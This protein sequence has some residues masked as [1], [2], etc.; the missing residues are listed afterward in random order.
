MK[1]MVCEICGSQSI[2][3]ENGVFICQEC[4]TEYSLEE[5]KKLLKEI[6]DEA[7]NVSTTNNQNEIT[8]SERK[9]EKSELLNV[10]LAWTNVI[11]ILSDQKLYKINYLENEFWNG[12]PT[13]EEVKT[14]EFGST[15]KWSDDIYKSHLTNSYL[16][17]T[18]IYL[19]L[20]NKKIFVEKFPQDIEFV[21]N[22][23]SMKKNE[24]NEFISYW[25]KCYESYNVEFNKIRD[26]ALS[27]H[28]KAFIYDSC[29]FKRIYESTISFDISFS[30]P[31][32]LYNI[33]FSKTKF[34]NHDSKDIV[35]YFRI[36]YFFGFFTDTTLENMVTSRSVSNKN[37]PT[38]FCLNYFKNFYSYKK[39]L[40][41]EE[42]VDY[43][44]EFDYDFNKFRNLYTGLFNEINDFLNNFEAN[45]NEIRNNIKD[46]TY[47]I[48]EFS[49]NLSK[50]FDLPIKYRNLD[51]LIP[52]IELLLDGR[53]ETWKDAVNL[54]ED[55]RYKTELLINMKNVSERIDIIS[56]S[57]NKLYY[58][59]RKTNNLLQATNLS[60]QS[61]D[62][63]MKL[64]NDIQL[65]VEFG[66]I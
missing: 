37:F 33:D 52:L 22:V 45:I 17:N 10:L 30:E 60:L 49:K 19:H 28:S 11:K 6:S 43:T 20:E 46:T 59:T 29:S 26:K 3:K 42:R 40:F 7:V 41:K 25:D 13:F 44:V 9:Q 15:L 53:A 5:A 56:N 47:E 38:Y 4:G 58:E 65:F 61:I 2:K 14:L 55:E 23:L 48:I 57:I 18:G 63:R 64:S 31:N 51:S 21:I 24:I 16:I 62:K 36:L 32:Y 50:E 12:N 1:K 54:F 8:I 34:K 39:S 35:N 66:I 27:E